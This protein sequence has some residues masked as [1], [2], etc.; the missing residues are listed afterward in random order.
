MEK[1]LSVLFVFAMVG[2]AESD[3]SSPIKKDAGKG[4]SIATTDSG[5]VLPGEDGGGGDDTSIPTEDTGGGG[6]CTPAVGA[7]ST[8]GTFPQCGCSAGENCD[9][10]TVDGK[11]E[12]Q[13]AGS[14]GINDSCNDLGQCQKG[15]SCIGGLCRSFCGSDSDCG[16]GKCVNATYT[17]SGSTT[18][19]DVP[20][21]KICFSSCDPITPSAGC[22]SQNCTLL[23]DGTATCVGA[24]T[25]TGTGACSSDPNAC[26]PGYVC[27]SSGDCLH[28]CRVGGPTSDCSGTGGTCQSFSTPAYLGSVEYGVCAP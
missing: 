3:N 27:L 10:T 1:L 17:P 28:W 26:A 18:P 15:S 13:T 11:G 5:G 4:D 2:C 16:G 9:I 7:G 6:T 20:G 8:C 23:D 22:G 14:A 24:G 25:A 19:V 12:C 21:F